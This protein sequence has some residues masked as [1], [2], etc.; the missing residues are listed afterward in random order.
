MKEDKNYK[1]KRRQTPYRPAPVLVSAPTVPYASASAPVPSEAVSVL[2]PAP[3]EETVPLL[4]FPMLEATGLVEHGFSTRLGGA[5][6]GMFTSLNLSF[7][8]GDDQ[9][10]VMENFRRL[11]RTFGIRMD[12]FVFTDQTHTTNVVQV[13]EKDA[14]RGLTL[15]PGFKDVDGLITDRPGLMLS[16][17]FADCV[18]LYFVDPVRKAIGLSHSGWRGTVN[19]MGQATIQAMHRAFGTEAS[20]LICAIGPSI[21]SDCYEVGM[22]VA[23]PFARGFPGR[24]DEI[25]TGETK[26]QYL[27]RHS[28]EEAER[29]QEEKARTEAET[30]PGYHG[31]PG[32]AGKYM[33][34]LWTANRIVLEEAGVRTNRIQ[35]TDICTCCNS[36]L[37]FSHRASHGKR[38]NL[39]AFLMLKEASD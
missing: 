10:A 23:V 3:E 8:R 27:T 37:L 2:T 31:R 9:E 34:D 39:G 17:F 13:T 7:H 32:F 1:I 20:D 15:M 24:V 35:V 14:G 12:Q 18:P 29:A 38:G 21:C 5:S 19:R 26:E 16:A 11:A 30:V 25:L 4:K 36:E 6:S 22:D 33:L 28:R